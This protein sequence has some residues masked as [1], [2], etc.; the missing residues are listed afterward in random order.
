[1]RG[2]IAALHPVEI[3]ISSIPGCRVLYRSLW[4]ARASH[5]PRMAARVWRRGREDAKETRRS[6]RAFYN[7][8]RANRPSRLRPISAPYRHA[9]TVQAVP[10]LQVR[11]RE[12]Q[13]PASAYLSIFRLA[14]H[15]A[16]PYLRPVVLCRPTR[17]ECPDILSHCCPSN[18]IHC[19]TFRKIAVTLCAVSSS[20]T[21]WFP[22]TRAKSV[23][24]PSS[25]CAMFSTRTVTR[26]S[27]RHI[28]S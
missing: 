5:R 12:E 7:N 25:A 13:G 20:P 22:K 14:S 17:T 9:P 23:P 8:W 24:G 4:P 16:G 10:Q 18:P 6:T 3:G 19:P 1:M 11:E 27:L 28:V 21:S 26:S 2:A 15:S